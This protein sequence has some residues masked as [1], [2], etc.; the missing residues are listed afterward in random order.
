MDNLALVYDYTTNQGNFQGSATLVGGSKLYAIPSGQRGGWVLGGLA[1]A[2]N[3]T[4][5]AGYVNQLSGEI[6]IPGATSA[7]QKTWGSLKAL[8]R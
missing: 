8:Y 1:G 3:A 6:Q 7:T 4:V 2:P 5:P